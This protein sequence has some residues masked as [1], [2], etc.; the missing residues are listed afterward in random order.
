MSKIKKPSK[1]IL[2]FSLCLILIAAGMSYAL[3]SRNTS[4][5]SGD[6]TV[7]LDPPTKADAARVEANKKRLVERQEQEAQQNKTAGTGQLKTVKPAITY[8]GQYDNAIEVGAYVNNVFEDGGSCTATFTR[9][10]T[11]F[12]K[13]VQAVKNVSSVDCPTMSAASSDFASK[14]TWQVT[15]AYSSGTAQGASDSRQIEVK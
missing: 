14:G 11:Q 7:N 9:S 13:T 5:S 15:V 12:T 3:V 6:K 1:K 10:G 4:P 2:L 8:A